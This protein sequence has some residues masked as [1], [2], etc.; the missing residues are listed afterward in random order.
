MATTRRR[1]VAQT[2][3]QAVE[4]AQRE[5]ATVE[6]TIGP[7]GE[8]LLQRPFSIDAQVQKK[9][10]LSE[11]KVRVYHKRNRTMGL[12]GGD[13]IGPHEEKEI[14]E[15]SANHPRIAPHIVVMR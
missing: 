11:R 6:S 10:Q 2:A 8:E 12:V 15:E 5:G 9:P 13:S 7:D 3:A 4:R 1:R 14:S